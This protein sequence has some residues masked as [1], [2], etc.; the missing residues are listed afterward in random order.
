MSTEDLTRREK[1][2]G[3]FLVATYRPAVTLFLILCSGIVAVLE[4]V[5]VSFIVP[6]IEMAQSSGD[7]AAQDDRIVEA[8]VT[9][10]EIAGIPFTLGYIVAT[11]SVII[12]IRYISSFLVGWMRVWLRTNYVRDLQSRA[13]RSALDARVAY[14][15]REGSDDVLNAIVTQAEYAGKVIR[16]F[17][18]FF[19]QVLL[20]GMYLAIAFYISPLM[21]V[22]AGVAIASLTFL[23]RHVLE[24]GYDVGDQVAD[25]NE[26]IQQNVQTGTQ[27]IRDVKLIGMHDQLYDQFS[28][29]L[30]RFT[31]SSIK[32]GRNEAA[33][34]CAYNLSIA[35]MVFGL[36][37]VSITFADM[38]L[39]ALAVFLFIMF[40]LGP[41]VSNANEYFYKV[42]GRLPHLVRTQQFIEELEANEDIRGGDRPVPEPA[43]PIAF[44]DVSFA[45][46]EDE[47]VLQDLS[48]RV[49]E[50]EFIAFVGQSGE[51]KSTIASLLARLYAPD[52]G[53]ITA[54]GTPIDEFDTDE[55][56]SRIAFV[57]QD[58]YIFNETLREN[59]TVAN[60]DATE[61]EIEDAC[62]IAQ[63]TEFLD[64]LPDGYDTEL[65]DDGVRLSGGQRQRVALARALLED[66]DI[67]V[68][69]EATSD[70]DATIERRVQD[71]I[72]SM[73]QEY[74]IVAIAHRLSTVR[75]AD[76]IY[77]LEGGTIA[78][79]G[80]HGQLLE[81]EGAYAELYAVQ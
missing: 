38:S 40:Q 63:V 78:E 61:A 48:F 74:T 6:I 7:A 59:I 54:N 67:L 73:S 69:D 35:V 1:L 79:H 22:V 30:D 31:D 55:W 81:Q 64:E 25:A 66:A 70:L 13:F 58:P 71:G 46:E 50:G 47:P 26:G 19:E 65:G 75:D 45:Y 41:R 10:F 53:E 57:R 80:E 33:I 32:L 16:D 27:G 68:L 2:R 17:V 9:V 4:G 56:R 23:I 12:S 11:V 72:E 43:T 77:A 62:E 39:G 20:I 28:T 29:H 34:G 44:E 21:T 14:F 24:G 15:D 51:G 60:A 49:D 8:F 3:L 42:E 18:R 76:R 36:I 52:D 5:G 37:Y